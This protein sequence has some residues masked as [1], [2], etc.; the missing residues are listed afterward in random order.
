VP[1]ARPLNPLDVG[2][3][4]REASVSAA[5][6]AQAAL[7]RDP[8]VG[9]TFIVV[10]TT[11]QLEQKVRSWGEAAIATR[12][13]TA[14]LL[15]PGRLIDGARKALRELGCPYTDRMDDA[16]R[17]IRAAVDYGRI[18]SSAV[19]PAEMP[20]GFATAVEACMRQLPQGQLTE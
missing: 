11:P 13:P 10:A 4:A 6:D 15:T 9:V 20:P 19:E 18:Q 5:S 17:V 14:I 12:T 8:T 2:G 7:A 1:P 3:L 16:I